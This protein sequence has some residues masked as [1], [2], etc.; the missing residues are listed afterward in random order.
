MT[1][2]LDT[3][4][5]G[6]PTYSSIHVLLATAAVSRTPAS[7]PLFAHPLTLIVLLIYSAVVIEKVQNFIN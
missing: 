3:F 1:C 7:A 5:Q 2:G 6:L 4:L